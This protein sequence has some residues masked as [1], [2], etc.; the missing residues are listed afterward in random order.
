MHITVDDN[1]FLASSNVANGFF[2]HHNK[3][4]TDNI[5]TNIR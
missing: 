5:T 3:M 4:A 1:Y 2:L